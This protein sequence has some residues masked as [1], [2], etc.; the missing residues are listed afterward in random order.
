MNGMENRLKRI[1][2]PESGR[3]LVIAIDHGYALGPMS[4]IVDIEKTISALDATGQI[5]AWLLTKGIYRYCFNPQASPGVIMR[6]SG[7]A[8]IAGPD[9]T[10]EALVTSV[11]ESL[12]L[13]SDAVAVSAFVGSEFEH[14]TLTAMASMADQCHRW[15]LPLLGVMGLGKEV[16]EKKTDAK[17]IALG[18]RVAAEHGADMVKT[19]YT[20]NDFDKVV[21]GCPVPIMIAGGPKCDTDLDTLKMIHGALAAGAHGIVMGRNIWQ[22]PN[23]PQLL[24]AVWHLI[25]RNYSV[26]E[27]NQL[28]TEMI[29]T[30]PEPR[31]GRKKQREIEE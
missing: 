25:H 20:E 27:A 19:Y 5:D 24:N 16:G 4:G 21:A 23:A 28:L 22:S 17:F 6:A 3:S 7:G 26:V 13:G 30:K 31:R 9:I 15:N 14:E 11:E 29:Q 1:F 8:T 12:A 10:R 2:K 18:A